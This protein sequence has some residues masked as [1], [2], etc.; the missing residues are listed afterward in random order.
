MLN[1][2]GEQTI[3]Q[4]DLGPHLATVA[5]DFSEREKDLIVGGFEGLQNISNLL[6]CILPVSA[7]ARFGLLDRRLREFGVLTPHAGACQESP[8]YPRLSSMPLT[9]V[10]TNSLSAGKSATKLPAS[11]NNSMISASSVLGIPGNSAK[12]IR[13]ARCDAVLTRITT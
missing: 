1:H 9:R 2:T 5:R 11:G 7:K 10:A 12:S 3:E 4:A 8:V 13:S 6:I